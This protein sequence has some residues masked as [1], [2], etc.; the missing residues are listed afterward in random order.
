[1]LSRHEEDKT[2]KANASIQ[3]TASIKK[4]EIGKSTIKKSAGCACEAHWNE[5]LQKWVCT[6]VPRY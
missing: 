3:E 4:D 6:E 2:K 1:M 5:K